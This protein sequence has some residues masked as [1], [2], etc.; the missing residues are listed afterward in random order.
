MYVRTSV[1]LDG[2]WL[3]QRGDHVQALEVHVVG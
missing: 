1:Y 2:G 3:A